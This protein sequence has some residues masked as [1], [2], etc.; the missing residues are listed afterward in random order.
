MDCYL[1]TLN[2]AESQKGITLGIVGLTRSG[3]NH[4]LGVIS[5][6]VGSGRASR[7][8][9]E[10]SPA[11]AWDSMPKSLSRL[12]KLVEIASLDTEAKDSLS[13]TP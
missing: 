12:G 13:F 3:G 1:L 6:G 2:L 10:P 4:I 9:S 8:R 7:R 11:G 5:F